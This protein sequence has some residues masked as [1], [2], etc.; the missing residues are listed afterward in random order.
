MGSEMAGLVGGVIGLGRCVGD[1]GEVEDED[2]E[3]GMGWGWDENEERSG[4]MEMCVR[5]CIPTP[6]NAR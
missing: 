2:W 5:T 6:P 4:D 3:D 1:G